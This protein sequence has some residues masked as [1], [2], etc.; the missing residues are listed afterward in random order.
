MKLTN[1][2]RSD[3]CIKNYYYSTLRKHL[4]RINKSLKQGQIAKKLGFK[5]KNL[6]ADYLYTL[7]RDRKVSYA[8][9]I[10]IDPK[11]FKGLE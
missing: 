11:K 5:V 2:F 9:I 7:V 6:T 8:T 10:A 4:R 3:N 1:Y